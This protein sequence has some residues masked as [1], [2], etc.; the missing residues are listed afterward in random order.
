M[1]RRTLD[2]YDYYPSTALSSRVVH[3]RLSMS[4]FIHV[5]ISRMNAGSFM[6]L[7]RIN[8]QEVYLTLMTLRRSLGQRSRLSGD[9]HRYLVNSTDHG[10]L[11]GFKPKLTYWHTYLLMFVQWG[12]NLIRLRRS[13]V[14]IW[15][16]QKRFPVE[17]HRSTCRRDRWLI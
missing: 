12:Q 13:L 5:F 10:P 3:V 1:Q 17:A 11:N 8:H 9:G 2:V 14:Q 7:I 15:R 16:L 4:P 6:K